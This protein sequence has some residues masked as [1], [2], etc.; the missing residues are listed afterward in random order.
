MGHI[1]VLVL[2]SSSPW[3]KDPTNFLKC[4]EFKSSLKGGAPRGDFYHNNT[5][6][7]PMLERLPCAYAANPRTRMAYAYHAHVARNPN[8][9]HAV[10]MPCA[11][12]IMRT[13]CACHAHAQV[14]KC[15]CMCAANPKDAR[16]RARMRMRMRTLRGGE[17]RRPAC[18][19]GQKPLP[20]GVLGHFRID[21]RT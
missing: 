12:L 20:N 10:R 9:A 6:P 3:V 7:S 11:A 14:S 1:Q 8:V 4:S 2:E 18:P 5:I 19:T 21:C 17:W 13:P 16:A 15:V